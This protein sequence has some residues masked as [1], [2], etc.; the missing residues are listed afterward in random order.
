MTNQERWT[1]YENGEF[2]QD[3]AIELLDWAGY[4]ATTGLDEITDPLQKA[5]TRRAIQM[6]LEDVSY[7]IKIVAGLVIS[8]DAIKAAS[9]ED[10]TPAFI[11]PIIVSIMAN[12]LAWITGI[13][14]IQAV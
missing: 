11:H 6:I 5:Q 10:V 3:I 14:E 13:S 2:R 9:P 4:W 12:K 7:T 8:D 1:L